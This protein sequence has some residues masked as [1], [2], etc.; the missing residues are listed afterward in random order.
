M[1]VEKLFQ[2]NLRQAI[3][4]GHDHEAINWLAGCTDRK[5]VLTRAEAEAGKQ[6]YRQFMADKLWNQFDGGW[7]FGSPAIMLNIGMI[8][9]KLAH[10][11]LG[12]NRH[13]WDSYS[14]VY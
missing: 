12:L 1:T 11:R 7:M 10:L 4:D 6:T 2:K 3:K 8:P 14:Q 13:C 5:V 9:S